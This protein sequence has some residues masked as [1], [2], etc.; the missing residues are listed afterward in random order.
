[1]LRPRFFT[2]RPAPWRGRFFALSLHL[3]SSLAREALHA[4]SEPSF[5]CSTVPSPA[6]P[7]LHLNAPQT[8]I[9][10]GRRGQ[11]VVCLWS[12]RQLSTHRTNPNDSESVIFTTTEPFQ[13]PART[14]SAA[15]EHMFSLSH[16]HVPARL[17]PRRN[18]LDLSRP[19][20]VCWTHNSSPPPSQKP[21]RDLFRFQKEPLPPAAAEGRQLS[22]TR[23]PSDRTVKRIL[24]TAAKLS[25]Q[26]L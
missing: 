4:N 26:P 2:N 14:S 11:E 12:G 18:N 23:T 24:Q 8:P 13:T 5:M 19:S 17:E 9:G 25:L 22:R 1:M 20:Y 3:Q 7:N 15:K 6:T 10:P 16:D 21:S